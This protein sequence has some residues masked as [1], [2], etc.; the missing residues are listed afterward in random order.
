MVPE[1]SS[2]LAISPAELNS[3]DLRNIYSIWDEKRQ[4]RTMPARNDLL[5]RALGRCLRNVSLIGIPPGDRDYEF[6]V[7]GDVHVQAYGKRM[8]D[9]IAVAPGF[10]RVM[11]ATLDTVF[12]TRAPLAFRGMIGRDAGD[13]RFVWLETI[14]LPLGAVNDAV[15]H[16]IVATVYAPRNGTWPN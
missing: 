2:V 5:P 7:I 3:S 6:R 12:N 13:A 11:K 9:L 14:Y 1:K 15:D 16:I 4:S 10:G 8:S